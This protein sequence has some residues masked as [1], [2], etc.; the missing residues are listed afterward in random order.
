MLAWKCCVQLSSASYTFTFTQWTFEFAKKNKIRWWMSII[1]AFN[2]AHR[3]QQFE[4]FGR[5]HVDSVLNSLLVYLFFSLFSLWSLWIFGHNLITLEVWWNLQLGNSTFSLNVFV[6]FGT[7]YRLIF[8]LANTQPI[9]SIMVENVNMSGTCIQPH[10]FHERK[11]VYL[12]F[13]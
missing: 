7:F 11:C 5:Y 12:Y 8:F 2:L 9:S 3:C 13:L 1:S 4:N 10:H 6:C